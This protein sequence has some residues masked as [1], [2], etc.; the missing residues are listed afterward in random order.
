VRSISL[1]WSVPLTAGGFCLLLFP[2]WVYAGDGRS[3]S[4]AWQLGFNV[5]LYYPTAVVSL[6]FFG[7]LHRFV[8]RK[9]DRPKIAA[10]YLVVAH[11]CLA[12][13]L[14]V[15]AFSVARSFG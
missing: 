13:A 14:L 6:F 8:S 15:M 10:F 4:L 2:L 3:G 9:A 7:W 11:A 5:L 1:R 12:V